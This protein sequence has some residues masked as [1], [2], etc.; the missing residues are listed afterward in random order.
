M[1]R[2]KIILVDDHQIVR[3]G[4]KALLSDTSYINIIGEAK[5]AYEFFDLLKIETPDVV[6]LDISL[7]KMSGIEVSKILS[8]EFPEIKKLM[9]SMYVSEDFIFN[10][11]KS[12]IDGYLPKNTTQE[13]LLFAI[14]EVYEGREYFNKSISD[15]ILKSY[16][17]NAKYG[18]TVS[19]NNLGSLTKREHEIL[20]YV[21]EGLSNP[22]IAEI[23]SISVR[24][25]ETHKT[26]I[27]R[28]LDLHSIVDLVKFAIKNNII[29]L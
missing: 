1:N 20:F 19:D 16:V 23:L 28:K 17:K 25:V 27:L 9:L 8:A 12:G 11:L 4:I 6:L 7:P 29:E 10:A 21:V 2:I 13:E 22:K 18:N 26:S 14:K 15:T 3:D 24:T 5:S